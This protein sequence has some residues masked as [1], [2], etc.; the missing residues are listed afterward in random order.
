[1]TESGMILGNPYAWTRVLPREP[2]REPPRVVEGNLELD[3]DLDLDL[4]YVEGRR[5]GSV[6]GALPGVSVRLEKLSRLA[7]APKVTFLSSS[8]SSSSRVAEDGVNVVLS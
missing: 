3:L 4:R 1:M 5:A 8:L 2:P 6:G 7:Q